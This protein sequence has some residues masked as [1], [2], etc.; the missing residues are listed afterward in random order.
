[1]SWRLRTS[2]AAART[3]SSDARSSSSS[4]VSPP[5]REA[6]ALAFAGLRQASTTVAPLRASTVAV[7]RPSPLLAP[8]TRATRPV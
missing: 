4:S 5:M 7:S 6:A 3:E 1:V 8:V 2:S